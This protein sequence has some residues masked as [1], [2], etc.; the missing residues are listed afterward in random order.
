MMQP[1]S[2]PC[3]LYDGSC[4][5]CSRE[6]ASYRRLPSDRPIDWVDI[7][8]LGDQTLFG[9]GR[10]HLMQRFHVV[11]PSGQLISG[12]R[13]FVHIWLLLPGWRYLGFFSKVPGVL[14]MMELGYR[15]FL[16]LRPRLQKVASLLHSSH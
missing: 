7:S 14:A 10:S 12:A 9:Q 13:A 11:T 16:K 15:G 2:A 5:I 6:I 4:P 3:V 1:S 8:Y